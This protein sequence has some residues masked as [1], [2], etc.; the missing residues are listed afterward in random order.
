MRSHRDSDLAVMSKGGLA[1]AIT[2]LRNNDLT[3]S[4]LE[5]CIKISYIP[6]YNN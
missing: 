4:S 2:R 1:L 6:K 3:I 5:I